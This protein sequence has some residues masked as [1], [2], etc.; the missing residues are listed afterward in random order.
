MKKQK[1]S[2]CI[3]LFTLFVNSQNVYSQTVN[4]SNES[5]P[6]TLEIM[7]F[8][9][10]VTYHMFKSLKLAQKLPLIVEVDTQ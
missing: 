4:T 9:L 3:L 5:V 2:I 7:K 10:I 6:L 8:I 1:L